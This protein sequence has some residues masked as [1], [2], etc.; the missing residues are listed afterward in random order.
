MNSAQRSTPTRVLMCPPTYYEIPAA[1]NPHMLRADIPIEDQQPDKAKTLMQWTLI[2]NSY[3]R[4]GLS[5]LEM[6]PIP[7]FWDMIFTANGAWGKDRTLVLSNF[8]LPIRRDEKEHFDRWLKNLDCKVFEL[9]ENLYFEGQGDV[10]TLSDVYLFGYGPRSAPEAREYVEL[11]LELKKPTVGL[12]LV[13]HEFYHLDTCCT[14]LRGTKGVEGLVYYPGAFSE[15]S[16]QFLRKLPKTLSRNVER[17][18]FEVSEN[19][20][21][22]FVCNSV[23]FEDKFML[24]VPFADYS[25]EAF[26]LSDSFIFMEDENDI[27]YREMVEREPD[28]AEFI[29]FL[30]ELGYKI[31]PIY[32]SELLKSG[33]GVR[34]TTLFLD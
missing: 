18:I 22:C 4:F 19:L 21:N 6:T 28:Y 1:E 16:L 5:V 25:D 17:K 34:C 2:R 9:P 13:T 7:R 14:A 3:Q 10:I 33:A 11:L 8:R 12:E 27:R 32:T 24:N 30:R 31:L 23:F 20:A 15:E 29:V 26:S